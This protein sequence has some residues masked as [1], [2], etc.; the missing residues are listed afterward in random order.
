MLGEDGPHETG[1]CPSDVDG[2][3]VLGSTCAI[4][5]AQDSVRTQFVAPHKRAHH[6]LVYDGQ[7][8]RVLLTGGNSPIASGES[9][10]SFN[11]LWAFDGMHWAA[12]PS[13]GQQVWGMRLAFDSRRRRVL[14]FGGN[15]DRRS[16]SDVRLLEND[17]WTTLGQHSEMPAADAGFVYDSRRDRFI[18]F[19]GSVGDGSTYGDTWEFAGG[20]WAKV[21]SQS[22]RDG[23]PMRWCSTS[24]AG[25]PL[26]LAAPARMVRISDHRDWEMSGSSTVGGGVPSSSPTDLVHARAPARRMTRNEASPWSSAVS[27]TAVS[28]AICGHGPDLSGGNWLMCHPPARRHAPWDNSLMTKGAIESSSS[29]GAR[30]GRMVT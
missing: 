13:S 27:T 29:A 30:D 9:Y 25:E 11:D 3:I 22:P 15:S 7:R 2:V 10:T 6:A 1:A 24:G 28:S 16:I 17:V 20:T 5:V 19:G 14:S 4:T 26:S 8:Q 23:R 21:A 12:L 18:A